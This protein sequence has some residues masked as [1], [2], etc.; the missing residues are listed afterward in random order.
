MLTAAGSVTYR[1]PVIA[2][3][4]LALPIGAFA[5]ALVA[6]L[7]AVVALPS[8]AGTATSSLSTASTTTQ[9]APALFET[10]PRQ[11]NIVL[12]MADDMRADDIRWMPQVRRLVARQGLSFDNS[13]SPYPLCCPARASF[14]TGQYAHNHKVWWHE[15]PEG[16]ASFDDSRTLATSLSQSGY[17]TGFIGKYLNRYGKAASLVSGRPSYTYVPRG[18]DDWRAAIENPRRDG[19]HGDT[20][21]YFDTPFNVNGTVDN[22]YRGKYQSTVIGDFSVAM[23]K[24]FSAQ[25][26]PFFMYVNYVAPHH[27]AP[28]EPGDIG[29]RRDR[30][31]NR[32][33]FYTPARPK[34]VWGK[35][36]RIIDRGAGLPRDGGPAEKNVNDKPRFF[37]SLP[38]PGPD[39]R[40]AL[41][42][43]TRQRAE[44][45][46]V[47]DRNI[48]R[49][50]KQLKKSG[51]WN[52]TVFM[53]TS[54]NGYYLGEHRK[55]SGKV[56]AHEPSFRV[57]FLVTGPGMR[58]GEVR[59]EP[60]TTID[61]S[62]S[63]LDLARAEPPRLADGQSRV[64]T[65]LSGDRGWISPIVNEATNLE[66]RKLRSPGFK[67]RRVAIGIRTARYSYIR[68]RTGEHELY[69][70][71][72]DPLQDENV[73]S[74]K[75]Y[76]AE[77]EALTRV[78]KKFKDCDGSQCLEPLPESLQ[79]DAGTTRTMGRQYWR[80]WNRTYGF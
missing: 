50:I 16:Y 10:R 18:W 71:V 66:G 64:S 12:V 26:K 11:P 40:D 68:N 25:K 23:T 39:E 80:D 22:S 9:V 8:P 14:L 76:K 31:G 43:V 28:R 58:S 33:V 69:D 46:Y 15:A 2:P 65:M 53:F 19:I 56:R 57:P 24:R 13:F 37:R 45:I 20:Y 61:A 49:L 6:G 74:A 44:S 60:I 52:N 78:W 36:D 51:E 67:D 17:R 48:G 29:V 5:L 75:S 63:I 62:A 34:S 35:F 30:K 77:R 54:D 42:N 41:R 79:T 32:Q 47:M 4:N 38:E 59:Y 21:N 7:S 55:R 70:L 72:R 3:R 73:F 27:G 1:S